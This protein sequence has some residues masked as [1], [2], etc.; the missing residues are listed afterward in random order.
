MNKPEWHRIRDLPEG[1]REPFEKWL[2]HG[3]HTQPVMI[4]VGPDEQDAYYQFDY[5]L[6]KEKAGYLAFG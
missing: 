5:V 3:G 1:D 6:W 2:K 4:D